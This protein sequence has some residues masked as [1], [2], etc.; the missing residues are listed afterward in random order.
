MSMS[1]KDN[2]VPES[3]HKQRI[4][5]KQQHALHSLQNGRESHIT[6][7]AP[8]EPLKLKGNLLNEDTGVL[9]MTISSPLPYKGSRNKSQMSISH[10]RNSNMKG[11]SFM[12]SSPRFRNEI[13]TLVTTTH[14][15]TG[16]VVV[17][18]DGKTNLGPGYYLNENDIQ[19]IRRR[20]KDVVRTGRRNLSKSNLG[21]LTNK[22]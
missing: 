2:S 19:I 17:I 9:D 11:V 1:T 5:A 12:S 14:P 6:G 8:L 20:Y 3:S 16:Q 7:L 4:Q 18:N 22:E 15:E 21:F 13:P 10:R